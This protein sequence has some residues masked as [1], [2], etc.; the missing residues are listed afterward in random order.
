MLSAP[1]PTKA[2]PEM[3]AQEVC[4]DKFRRTYAF[5]RMDLHMCMCG[6]R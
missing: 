1:V 3:T 5:G 2:V 4:T 6:G